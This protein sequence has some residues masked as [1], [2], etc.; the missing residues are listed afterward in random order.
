MVVLVVVVEVVSFRTSVVI[1]VIEIEL[2][3]K[4]VSARQPWPCRSTTIMHY[5]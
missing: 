3:S 4:L 5:Y 1:I 2:K